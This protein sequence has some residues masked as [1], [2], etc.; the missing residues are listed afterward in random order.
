MNTQ[1]ELA[2]M[3]PPGQLIS[4][5]PFPYINLATRDILDTI[6]W[7]GNHFDWWNGRL[8]DSRVFVAAKKVYY[9][10]ITRT[11]SVLYC[12]SALEYKK[13]YIVLLY[14]L[15]ATG[16]LQFWAVQSVREWMLISINW[17]DR[18]F[19]FSYPKE[20]HACQRDM[21][22]KLHQEILLGW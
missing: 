12:R 7:A 9:V 8:W 5:I 1:G 3:W 4:N 13:G 10:A 2:A 14:R 17:K 15:K 19:V 11:L 22:L 20:L 6:L 21:V 16:L 18:F